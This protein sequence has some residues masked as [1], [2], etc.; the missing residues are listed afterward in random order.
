LMMEKVR[1]IAIGRCHRIG[2][3]SGGSRR[4][5]A[6]LIGAGKLGALES[7]ALEPTARAPA[8]ALRRDMNHR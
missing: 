3:K 7:M 4:L 2:R 5:I 1:S 8:K 6:A